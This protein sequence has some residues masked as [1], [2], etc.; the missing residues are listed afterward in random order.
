MTVVSITNYVLQR[1]NA[2]TLSHLVETRE[3]APKTGHAV[4]APPFLMA[5]DQSADYTCAHCG[6]VL[7]QSKEGQVRGLLIHCSNCGSYN[8]TDR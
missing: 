6:T 8:T 7:L 1:P 5:S 4:E 3:M 2:K